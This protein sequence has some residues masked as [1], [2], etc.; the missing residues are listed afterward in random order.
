MKRGSAVRIGVVMV[1]ASAARRS[2][3]EGAFVVDDQATD[4][5]RLPVTPAR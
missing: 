3:T 4:I 1:L 5:V 2:A